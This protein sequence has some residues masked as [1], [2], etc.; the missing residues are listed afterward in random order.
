MSGIAGAPCTSAMKRDVRKAFTDQWK[1]D[2][3]AFGYTSEERHRADRFRQDHAE[4]GLVCPLID[5][6]LS[7]ADCHGVIERAGIEMAAMYRLGFPNNNCRGCVK[8]QS[9]RGW[10]LTRLHFPE[11]FEQRAKLS[12][13]LGVRLVKMGSGDRERL[14]LDELPAS[15]MGG[16]IP[17]IECSLMCHIAEQEIAK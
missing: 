10:N 4:I 2:L 12:R 11:I 5:A 6:S 14:F 8:D 17:D 7:K 9:A 15:E 16:E 3:Q 1:P 13:E